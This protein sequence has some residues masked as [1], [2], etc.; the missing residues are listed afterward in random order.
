MWTLEKNSE[1]DNWPE[2]EKRDE[3]QC[4]YKDRHFVSQLI[5]ST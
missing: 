1:E 5:K 3:V 2:P 4:N